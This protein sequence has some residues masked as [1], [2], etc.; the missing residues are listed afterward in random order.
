MK[1]ILRLLPN[2]E[3]MEFVADDF[4]LWFGVGRVC[5]KIEQV[6]EIDGVFAAL[7]I[8]GEEEHL[9]ITEVAQK[10]ELD[11]DFSKYEMEVVA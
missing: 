2:E 1:A 9:D 11:W 10:L 4:Y 7:I 3:A 6:L 8:S 5:K